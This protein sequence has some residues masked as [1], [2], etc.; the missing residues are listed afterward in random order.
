MSADSRDDFD[1]R[2]AGI[3]LT[4]ASTTQSGGAVVT[5]AST[6]QPAMARRY[7]IISGRVFALKL[8]NEEAQIV[9]LALFR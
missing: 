4:N 9:F 1:S 8:R 2:R 5:R 3:F 7:E 6:S